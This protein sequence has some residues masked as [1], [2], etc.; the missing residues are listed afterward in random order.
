[1]CRSAVTLPMLREPECS[2]TQTR[3]S[4]WSTQISMKWLPPPSVPHWSAA[5][6]RSLGVATDGARGSPHPPRR[7]R[8]RPRRD[9]ARRAGGSPR[10]CRAR[11]RGAGPGAS[12]RAPRRPRRVLTAAI[13][14]PMSTPTAAGQIAP[15][16][17]I[18]LPTV[19]PMPQ[20][21]S[22]MA[23]T[24]RKTNG[25]LARLEQLPAGR[26]L[27]VRGPDL[28]RHPRIEDLA[29]RHVRDAIPGGRSGNPRRPAGP[30][31]GCSSRTVRR[32]R[33]AR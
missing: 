29:D 23:A 27:E 5:F 17:A 13:P 16:V 9:A 4:S 20:C 1:M 22:A 31:R 7:P 18:T 33:R 3:A 24:W 26:V 30:R 2:R 11:S 14:Q 21:V 12:P 25:Q 8:A 10:G 32:A 19:A 6:L 28:D 15:S